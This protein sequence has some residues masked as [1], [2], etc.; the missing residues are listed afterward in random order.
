[1]K[2][3]FFWPALLVL[4]IVFSCQPPTTSPATQT[5]SP[6]S[7]ANPFRQKAEALN[8]A[9]EADSALVYALQG[10]AVAEK[11]NNWPEWGKSKVQEGL[12]L[13]YLS[14]LQEAAALM[15]GLEEKGTANIPAD[16]DF[17]GAYYNFA[18]IIYFEQGDFEKALQYGLQEIAFYKANGNRKLLADAYHNISFSYRSK[19]DFDRSAE[20]A[21]SELQIFLSDSTTS[22]AAV[23][24]S[25]NNLSQVYYR[26]KDYNQAILSAQHALAMLDKDFPGKDPFDLIIAYNNLASAYTEQ[27]EF[28]PASDALQQALK[29]HEQ[30]RLN[31]N[32][33]STWQNLGFVYRRMGKYPEA[34]VYLLQAL[35]LQKS[36][37][38]D[39]HPSVGKTYRHL[40]YVANRLGD[41]RGALL[42]YQL[43]L[44]TLTD[45]FPHENIL[46][47]PAVQRVNAYLDFLL[48]LRDKG[49]TLR[50]LA[51]QEHNQQFLEASL[52]T[53][54]VA[55]SLLDT[56]RTEYQ[57]GSR[58]FWNREARPIVEGAIGTAL[59][60]HRLTKDAGYLEQAFRYT[61][62]S[63]ALLL[64]D[65]LRESAAKQKAGIPENLLQEEKDLKIDIA[66][67]K[68]Q[69]FRE[70]QKSE[71]DAAKIL[72]WQKEIFERRRDN[73]LLLKK[74]EASYPEYYRIKYSHEPLSVADVQQ[75][76]PQGSGILEYFSGDSAVFAF[77]LDKT[78]LKG[79][80]LETGA[81]FSD[82]L[83]TFIG[84]L[85]DRAWVLEHGRG[86]EATAQFA[87]DARAFWKTLAAPVVDTA[88]DNLIVIPD[89]NLSYLPFELLLVRD[90]NP[91][92]TYADLHY[93]LRQSSVRYEYSVA[94]TLQPALV[95][96]PR[97]LFAG[98]A[99]EYDNEGLT[100]AR[101]E[102]LGCRES[103]P[104]D[105]A[106]LGN[107]QEEVSQI[108]RQLGGQA[109]L[110]PKATEAHF[111]QYAPESR[112]LHLAMHGFLNDCDPLYSGLVFSRVV[113]ATGAD[114]LEDADGI[115]HAY[116][117]YNLP[118]NADLAV[119]SACNTG[120][121]QLAKGEGIMS[122]ARAFKYAGCA[123]ILMS[124]W[125]ADDQSTAQIM[126]GFY[127]YLK[128][129]LGKD[130]AI[131]RAKLDYL[132]AD[133]RNH[134]FFW[135]AF[136]L[137]GDDAPVPTSTP[138]NTW[139]LWGLVPLALFAGWYFFK[140]RKNKALQH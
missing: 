110:G 1:M 91:N 137:I 72:R 9:G 39:N 97:R 62:K 2:T 49:E 48:T 135:G 132:A 129:G 8:E 73:E 42:Y 103:N 16:D 125:Q 121:G 89:G 61:E 93:L 66:F 119:L 23:I 108:A 22:E 7:E 30:Y 41:L 56:M 123:N 94:M 74:L 106:A 120:R 70:Q 71:P 37:Y 76:L 15:P 127:Q 81:T 88:P 107:N 84:S 50:Q 24:S 32:I 27:G 87:A 65:A 122:L 102:D 67:Y 90:N 59:E 25:Y 4:C 35:E 78:G 17:W 6:K 44:K 139:L 68:K 105:F 138:W 140:T 19:G 80:Q 43:A 58:Q 116:E 57:E 10:A 101:G 20:Y 92:D 98:Y 55:M 46:A 38:G 40:G 52:A 18:A 75:K 100:T 26:K 47:N 131:R 118:L 117:I 136:V 86:K 11:A 111:K 104:S 109:L 53:F 77:Y 69:I 21:Q 114:T 83:N 36:Q 33:E 28:G 29:V 51:Q 113:G 85:R 64:A 133:S 112:I 124:L 96:K 13:Y 34:R 14:R 79:L 3:F 134:P 5:G 126:Q 99:P 60:I 130:E 45:S 95:Q 115:L 63:K 128:Q 12:A 54:D 82:K 31:T